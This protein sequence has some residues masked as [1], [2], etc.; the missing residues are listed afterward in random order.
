MRKRAIV[1]SIMGLVLLLTG[2]ASAL[3]FVNWPGYMFDL[4]HSS[5]NGAATTITPANAGALAPAWGAPFIASGNSGFEASPVVYNGSIYIGA[6]NGVFYQ[7]DE[8]TGAVIHSVTLG[9]ETACGTFAYGVEDTATVAPDPNR[10]GAATVYVAGG[11]GTNGTGGIYL[12]ALDASTL[13]PVWTT[14]P[15]TVDTQTAA[16]GW[17]SPVVSNGTISVAIASGCDQPLVQGGVGVVSQSGTLLGTYQTVPGPAGTLGGTIW[18]SPVASGSSTWVAT[19]NAAQTPN[20]P[21]GDSFSIVRLQ[22]TTKQ[23]SWT[24]PSQAGTDNDFGASPTLFTGLIGGTPTPMIGACNKNGTFYALRSQSLSAG[25]VWQQQVAAATNGNLCNS[26]AVWDAGANELIMGSTQ[27][28]T[29]SPGAIQALSPDA[30]APSRVIWESDLPCPV[31]GPPSEDGAGVLAVVT[32]SLP[33]NICTAGSTPSLY[34]YA[35]HSTVPNPSGSGPPVPQLL[36]TIALGRS[37]FSQP[38][39]ADGYLFVAT[40]GSLMA[41]SA[42]TP[43]TTTTTSTTTST[44]TPTTTSTPTTTTTTTPTTTGHALTA[45]QIKAQL[46]NQLIPSGRLAAIRALLKHGGFSFSIK[47]RVAGRVVISWY[48]LPKGARISRHVKP[49]LIATGK[50]SL[51]LNRTVKVTVKL[52]ASGRRMLKAARRLRLTVKGTYTSSGRSTVRVT[53]TFVLRR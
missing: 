42:P 10:G 29:G 17:A 3:A 34:L 13:Q 33:G 12:W 4:G 45:A 36:K 39:F 28:T 52:T 27:T 53:R 43:P 20:A 15:V 37:A 18:S 6:K 8:A 49:V 23:D 26:G 2:A 31:E 22:G 11:N 24:V 46:A 41:Y 9:K 14:D 35:A 38:A 44:P 47:M 40:E 16:V 25:P 51:A 30:S 7:L 19:G 5:V 48:Y 1:A 50:A 32:M 21:Q